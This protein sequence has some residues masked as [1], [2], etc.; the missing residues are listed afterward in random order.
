MDTEVGA[1]NATYDIVTGTLMKIKNK[2]GNS[3]SNPGCLNKDFQDKRSRFGDRFYKGR[4]NIENN[5][6][7]KTE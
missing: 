2:L 6:I 7:W 1:I 5:R 4:L 3:N